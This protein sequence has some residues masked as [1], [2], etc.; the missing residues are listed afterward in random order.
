[1]LFRRRRRM[2]GRRSRF[3]CLLWLIVFAVLVFLVL[4]V[5]RSRAQEPPSYDDV[6]LVAARMYCP[7]CEMVPLDRCFTEVCIQWKQDIAEQLAAGRTTDEIVADFV[8]RF[9]DQV[10]GVPQDSALRTVTLA[11]PWLLAAGVAAF[12]G[13]TLYR[14]RA[15]SADKLSS[16]TGGEDDRAGEASLDAYRARLENELKQ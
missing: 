15:S 14:L 2:S 10:V 6:N 3:G 9:G 8:A 13:Y 11:A 16:P 5:L 1:M 12:G 7:E 4:R